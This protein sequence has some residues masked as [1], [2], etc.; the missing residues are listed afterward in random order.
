[1][2]KS[3]AIEKAES[4]AL[5]A[6]RD[7]RPVFVPAVDIYEKEDAI[8]VRCDMPGVDEK[9][10]EITLEENVLTLSGVQ[11][12]GAPEGYENLAGEYQTGIFQ[13]SFAIAQEIDQGRI[14]ASMKHGVL[15]IQ[16]PKSEEAQPR[17][18]EIQVEK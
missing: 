15:D 11:Q 1:M 10:L 4:T 7:E 6:T 16:L 13:R 8:L 9:D 17:R 12:S 14:K 18:I 5:E 2:S 3:T